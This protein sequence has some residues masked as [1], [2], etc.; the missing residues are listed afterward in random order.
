MDWYLVDTPTE[1]TTLTPGPYSFEY[2]DQN[3]NVINE[4]SFDIGF[5]LEGG[6]SLD[7]SPFVFTIPYYDNTSDI[8]IKFNGSVIGQKVISPNSPSVTLISPDNGELYEKNVVIDWSGDDIDGD[9]LSYTVLI[10]P[11]NGTTWEPIAFEISGTSFTWDISSIPPGM[12]Y[13]VKIIA[14][15]GFNTGETEADGTFTI[16]GHT[17]I[18]VVLK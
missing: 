3:S 13:R 18:P 8:A 15:D 11:D 5:S 10:S 16:I 7:Q 4:I 14:T 6:F 1:Q 17:Y 2:L 12:Q 9:S